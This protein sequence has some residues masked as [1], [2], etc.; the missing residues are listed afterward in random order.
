MLQGGFHFFGEIPPFYDLRLR[1]DFR[2]AAV[3]QFS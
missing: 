3:V 2:A 1:E